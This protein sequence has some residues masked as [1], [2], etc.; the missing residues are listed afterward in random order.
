[1]LTLYSQAT[2]IIS[3]NL[4]QLE[5]SPQLTKEEALAPEKLSHL[6]KVTQLING[7]HQKPNSNLSDLKYS[8]VEM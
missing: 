5:S 1:M 6:P 2:C 8:R 3:F 7:K 4:P